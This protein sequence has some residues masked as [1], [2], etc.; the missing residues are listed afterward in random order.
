VGLLRWHGLLALDLFDEPSE[1]R[2]ARAQG[3]A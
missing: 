2:R 3:V 1:A